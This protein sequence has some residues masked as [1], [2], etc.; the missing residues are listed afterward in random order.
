L[1]FG[2][3]IR[4]ESSV[5]RREAIMIRAML[6]AALLYS[7]AAAYAEFRPYPG[8]K[9]DLELH[10]AVA[11][12]EE[13]ATGGQPEGKMTLFV[14]SDSFDQVLAFY[15]GLG[16]ELESPGLPGLWTGGHERDLPSEIVIG[17]TGIETKPSGI[18]IKQAVVVLDGTADVD[19]S[20]D[21]VSIT[22]PFVTSS[23]EDGSKISYGEV[24]D[25]TVIVRFQKD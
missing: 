16:R 9:E 7:S 2:G 8:A 21:M 10:K 3:A 5:S 14:S 11:E 25:I 12:A 13:E 24:R 1:A 17:P 6:A 23:S 22:R 20:K 15:K 19:E 4:L 18:K